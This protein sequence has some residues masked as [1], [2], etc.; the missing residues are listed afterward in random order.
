MYSNVEV[1]RASP[2]FWG[3]QAA[4]GSEELASSI[5]KFTAGLPVAGTKGPFGALSRDACLYADHLMSLRPRALL[6]C[7]GHPHLPPPAGLVSQTIQLPP[8]A[9][10]G[11]I[12]SE[13]AMN[14]FD[15]FLGV[16]PGP[17]GTVVTQARIMLD[18]SD[19]EVMR[20][21]VENTRVVGSNVPLPGGA[22]KKTWASRWR[23]ARSPPGA[24]RAPPR[25]NK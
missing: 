25:P 3:F 24:S 7:L 22:C 20:V 1:F 15:P 12:I 18:P 19:G 23:F 5:F 2:F 14:L 4:V 11:R 17:A 9:D 16:L 10:D 8:G 21:A 13:V 6:A